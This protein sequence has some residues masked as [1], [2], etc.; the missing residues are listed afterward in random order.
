MRRDCECRARH[1]RI[2]ASEALPRCPA[3]RSPSPGGWV[4]GVYPSAQIQGADSGFRRTICIPP[5]RAKRID[6]VCGEV[7]VRSIGQ[8]KQPNSGACVGTS[9][10][11]AAVP[12]PLIGEGLSA[13]EIEARLTMSGAALPHSALSLTSAH[14]APRR[15]AGL[16]VTSSTAE[17][18]PFPSRGRT[19]RPKKLARLRMS[20][21]TLQGSGATVHYPLST[22]Y[23]KR[24]IIEA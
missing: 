11:A 6:Q 16:Q 20:G 17:R 19:K 12:L 8:G 10:T 1:F 23:K 5:R 24:P 2:A 21:A 22:L 13:V 18:S 15:G 7:T 9:S 14:N 3:G 4:G